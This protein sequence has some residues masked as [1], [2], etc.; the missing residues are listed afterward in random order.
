MKKKYKIKIEYKMK[1]GDY[2]IK[3]IKDDKIAIIKLKD[4]FRV[5][6]LT[7]PHMGGNI[8]IRDNAKNYSHSKK[9]SLTFQCNWHG[10]IYNIDGT[11]YENPNIENTSNIRV[12]SKFYNPDNCVKQLEKDLRLKIIDY[13]FDGKIIE[14][15]I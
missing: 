4:G 3:N 8:I 10:Y 12:K 5:L 15:E 1:E 14:I 7:C 6:S 9:N 2:F 13:K 11:F